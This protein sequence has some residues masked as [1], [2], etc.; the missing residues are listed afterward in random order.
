LLT[1]INFT[2]KN[3]EEQASKNA[4]KALVKQMRGAKQP[5]RSHSH[6]PIRFGD[7]FRM[8]LIV[9]QHHQQKLNLPS[10]ANKGLKDESNI[11]NSNIV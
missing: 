11:G 5:K 10:P 8:T 4:L 1:K 6:T 2:C 9:E 3:K 7:A